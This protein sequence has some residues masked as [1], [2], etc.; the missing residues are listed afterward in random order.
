M[1]QRY[2]S[3]SKAFHPDKQSMEMRSVAKE[4]F[5]QIEE[6]Y[7]KISNPFIRFIYDQVGSDAAEKYMK[8]SK[9][10]AD[11]EDR[12]KEGDPDL[13]EAVTQRL[14]LIRSRVA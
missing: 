11:L 10:F 4:Q 12:F 6:S 7:Q 2:Y 14:H 8:N 1:K 9:H 13:K 3:L 5:R